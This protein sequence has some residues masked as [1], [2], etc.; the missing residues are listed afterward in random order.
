MA[1]LPGLREAVVSSRVGSRCLA[2]LRLRPRS[3]SERWPAS[4]AASA[5][6]TSTMATRRT[7]ARPRAIGETS[8]PG[9]SQRRIPWR[10]RSGPV[11]KQAFSR[12]YWSRFFCF[13]AFFPSPSG[14]SSFGWCSWSAF[15][16]LGREAAPAVLQREVFSMDLPLG[17]GTFSHPWGGFFAPFWAPG[18]PSGR[19]PCGPPD[20]TGFSWQPSGVRLLPLHGIV[21]TAGFCFP[22]LG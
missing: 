22:V 16:V 6:T 10:A 13:P 5:S 12:G 15:P 8:L 14:R 2:S 7:R 9:A 11:I 18:G 3:S 21:S 1:A 4:R 19:L 20:G 17:C